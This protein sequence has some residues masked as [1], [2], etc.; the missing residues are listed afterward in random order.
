MSPCHVV[1][2]NKPTGFPQNLLHVS[3]RLAQLISSEALCK[4][5]A[6]C[7]QLSQGWEVIL[8]ESVLIVS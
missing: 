7:H 4:D 6:R 1:T 5:L 3:A 2:L 8:G